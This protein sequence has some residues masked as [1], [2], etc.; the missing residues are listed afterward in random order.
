M[1]CAFPSPPWR[2]KGKQ[3]SYSHLR[4]RE[5]KHRTGPKRRRGTLQRRGVPLIKDL[6]LREQVGTGWINYAA[7]QSRCGQGGGGKG[8]GGFPAVLLLLRSV[9]NEFWHWKLQRD[10]FSLH[11]D[12][13]GRRG[14]RWS[15]GKMQGLSSR[16][17]AF[18]VEALVGKPCKRMKVPDEASLGADAGSHTSSVF[19]GE[20]HWSL[21][22]SDSYQR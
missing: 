2:A 14:R 18:S 13:R 21:G 7:S 20:P 12:I 4:H 16:A 3:K 5:G 8:G 1:R 10:I 9:L 17:H 15:S 6:G 11:T 19:S 22:F